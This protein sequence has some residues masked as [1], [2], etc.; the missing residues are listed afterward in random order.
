MSSRYALQYQVGIFG[1]LLTFALAGRL[2]ERRRLGVKLC[3]GAVLFISTVFFWGN[4]CTTW[5]EIKTAP[6]RQDYADEV[7][8]M[9]LHYQE[10]PD[11]EL[12]ERF[13][14]RHGPERIRRALGILEEQGWNVYRENT[15]YTEGD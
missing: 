14:Y 3:R 2:W 8:A 15:K 6:Y 11:D 10:V 5:R 9:A 7:I 13:Q 4:L 1:I 12:E